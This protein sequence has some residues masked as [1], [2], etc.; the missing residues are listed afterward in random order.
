MLKKRWLAVIP[1]VSL[2]T[3]PLSFQ[4]V[5]ASPE[6]K[7]VQISKSTIPPGYE[8]IFN[9]A[10]E[11]QPIVKKGSKSFEVEFIQV[12]L[13]HFGFET[14]VDGVFGSHTEQQLR[15]LQAE[16]GLVQDGIVGVD[17]WT[18]LMEE[19]HEELFTV[20]TAIKYAEQALN[21]GDLLFSSD[22][23]LHKD[24]NDKVFYNLKAQSKELIDEGGSGTVGFYDVYQNGEVKESEPR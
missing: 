15:Q 17:T 9:W 5:D 8:A 6:N 14:E 16:N 12:M 18:L 1:A 11:E 21:N 7:A 3:A 23:V 20:E 4:S 13:T 24:S 2:F 19:Y 10:P 22:G